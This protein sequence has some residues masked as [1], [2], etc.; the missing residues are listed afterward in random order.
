MDIFESMTTQG[1]EQVVFVS[2]GDAGLKAIIAIHDTTLGPA[3]GGCRMYP[4]KTEAEAV[5]DAMRLSRAMTY[6]AAAAGLHLGG[7][8]SVIIGDPKTDKNEPLFRAFGKAVAS[9][10]G[11]YITAEDVGTD[12]QDM[13]FIFSETDYV[14]GVDTSR[15]GSGN[16]SPYTAFGVMQGMMA[17]V[18]RAF[19]EQ[20]MK[21]RTVAIQGLG[22][23]GAHLAGLLKKEGATVIATDVDKARAQKVG[24]EH[25][26]DEL[27]SPDDIFSVPCDVFAP[28]AMGLAINENT[29]DKLKCKVVAGGANNQLQSD[30]FGAELERRNIFYAPDF[31]INAGGLINVYT[32]LEGYNEERAMRLVRNLYYSVARIFTL[33]EAHNEPTIFAARRMVR[34]RI[35]E[36]ARLQPHFNRFPARAAIHRNHRVPAAAP[37]R[38]R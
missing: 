27:V 1:H 5:A 24:E 17:C 6:K 23:V 30:D 33:A 32:E 3:L 10:S 2:L 28:C 15:G 22:H 25:G 31:V 8:K 29:I 38:R 16:P 19:G 13:E 11:R 9:L 7:G 20:S 12:V 14:T 21:G 34:S 36:V 18:A 37:G 35:Q 26:L 4:Y